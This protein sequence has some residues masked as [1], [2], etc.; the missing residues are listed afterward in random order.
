M[1]FGELTN[2]WATRLRIDGIEY[3][4]NEPRF[5]TTEKRP[6]DPD[7][8]PHI[9]EI[10][11]WNMPNFPMRKIHLV[12]SEFPVLDYIRINPLIDGESEWI[13]FPVM[14]R[15]WDGEI[16]VGHIQ[17]PR[18]TMDATLRFGNSFYIPEMMYEFAKLTP[19]QETV[20]N[21]ITSGQM[22]GLEAFH[23]RTK[24]RHRFAVSRTAD[25]RD[26][27]FA[28]DSTF[29]GVLGSSFTAVSALGFKMM[30]E[31]RN[32]IGFRELNE[33]ALFDPRWQSV[34][35]INLSD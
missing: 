8:D 15:A 29:R 2:Q 19:I 20:L 27:N 5:R 34:L 17:D 9:V 16:N 26:R 23:P 12:A 24:M 31:N 6:L 4:N 22:F 13:T 18:R 14:F 7:I 28:Y 30:D 33:K 25:T 3:T 11:H 35:G 10:T 1:R 21:E 32:N